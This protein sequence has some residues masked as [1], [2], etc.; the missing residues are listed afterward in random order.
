MPLSHTFRHVLPKKKLPKK[1]EKT[2]MAILAEQLNDLITKVY[3]HFC[4][5]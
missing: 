5:V 2:K 1:Q 3:L 4:I